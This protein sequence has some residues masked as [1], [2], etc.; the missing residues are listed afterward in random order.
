[1]FLFSG[2]KDKMELD[3]LRVDKIIDGIK[4]DIQI[5]GARIDFIKNYGNITK[6]K[7]DKLKVNDF[8]KCRNDLMTY[9]IPLHVATCI[10]EADPKLLKKYNALMQKVNDSIDKEVREM[11]AKAAHETVSKEV[12][13]ILS[14]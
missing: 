2:K 12:K 10:I 6:R 7:N 3:N 4:K 13:N 11:E 8:D 1:M 5:A 9:P 14:K